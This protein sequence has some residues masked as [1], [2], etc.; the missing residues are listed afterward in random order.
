[1]FCIHLHYTL[2]QNLKVIISFVILNL[3]LSD[4]WNIPYD[5]FITQ[6]LGSLQQIVEFPYTHTHLY[7]YIYNIYRAFFSGGTQGYAYP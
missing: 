6:W 2:L 7:I 1:M 4:F 3:I 5:S